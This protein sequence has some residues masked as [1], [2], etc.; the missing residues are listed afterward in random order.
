MPALTT[1]NKL[2]HSTLE[3]KVW[4]E[5]ESLKRSIVLKTK[6]L[7]KLTIFHIIALKSNHLLQKKVEQD[8][9]KMSRNKKQERKKCYYEH[10][11]NKW[12]RTE[13]KKSPTKLIKKLFFGNFISHDILLFRPQIKTNEENKS[14]K[15][16]GKHFVT[17]T[18]LSWMNETE[19]CFHLRKIAYMLRSA[20]MWIAC[21]RVGWCE[22]IITLIWVS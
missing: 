14:K 9:K 19:N 18:N 21:V 17:L 22:R 11:R 3:T 16:G 2:R 5:I 13:K 12:K 8:E 6:L 1:A 20:L 4:N 15:A 7:P 10:T